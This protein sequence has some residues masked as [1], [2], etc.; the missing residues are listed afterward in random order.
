VTGLVAASRQ[1]TGPVG[2]TLTVT[3]EELIRIY[4]GVIEPYRARATWL[5]NDATV[6]Y[7]RGLREGTGAT[8]G[9]FLWQPGLQAG[10]PDTLLGK[11]VITDPAVA[12][13]AVSANAVVF[14]DFSGYYIRDV[15]GFRFE[16]SDDYAFAN[17]LVTF[18]AVLRTDAK[19]I[20]PQAM[21]VWRN[22]AT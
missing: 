5:M 10:V 9:N 19:L 14:G 7:V 3:P 16:R 4:H 18:R 21:V 15:A 12:T 17:D 11:P 6:A 1:L 22:S 8:A 13:M 2:T 20:D